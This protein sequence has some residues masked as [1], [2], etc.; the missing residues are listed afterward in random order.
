MATQN[1]CLKCGAPLK[2]DARQGCCPKCLFLQASAGM[3]FERQ[4][5]RALLDRVLARLEQEF[6]EAG[7]ADLFQRLRG[8]LV[9][10]V[11]QETYAE[12]AAGLG[13]TGE[14]VKKA[15]QRMRH[16][17]YALFR[18]EIRHTLADPAE[19]EEELRYLWAVMAG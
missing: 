17:Y 12:A 9:A 13:M 15:V 8:F 2:S 7:K 10:D 14:A 18:E 1:T 4:W 5:A 19:V 6:Q 3:F 16:R 11:G